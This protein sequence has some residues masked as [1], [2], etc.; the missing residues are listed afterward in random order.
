MACY[1]PLRAFDTG[2]LTDNF[3]TKYK[4][5][6][7]DVDRIH[8]PYSYVNSSGIQKSVKKFWQDRWITDWIPIPCGQCI[9]CRLDYSRSWADRCLLEAQQYDHNAFITLTYDSEHLP[10][11]KECVNVDT[12]EVFNWPSLD[13]DHLTDF[14]R[15]LRD[16]YRYNYNW[17]YEEHEVP[18]GQPY[19]RYDKVKNKYYV[20]DNPGI[21][22][23]ACGE[24]GSDGGRPHFHVLAF[25]LPPLPD[26]KH[27]FTTD[28]HEKIYH[29]DILQNKIW[30]RGICSIGELTWNSAAYVARYVV[31]KQK[32]DTSGLVDLCDELVSGLTPEKTRMSLK[33]GIAKKYYDENKH[34]F[35][36]TDEIVIS[37][38]NQVRTIKPPRYFDKL[39]DL[40]NF[41]PFVMADIKKARAENAKRS[42][43]D[44]LSRT[45]LTEQDYLAVKER[46]KLAQVEKLVRKFKS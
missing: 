26:M 33:P 5:C 41:D 4:I 13:F 10:A 45:T 21:R 8:L 30:K 23:Y 3:K 40:D 19:D 32:G 25:N 20:V 7:S 15:S 17:Q 1:H 29:S 35:Y 42:M 22:F 9:G 38:R 2:L 36:E 34:K 12:G 43:D 6:G 16:Y 37:V 44:Q 24:Y 27:W 28:D 11:F 39:Y 14:I 18:E 31:K 46:N